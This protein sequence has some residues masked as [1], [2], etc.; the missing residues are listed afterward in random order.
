M[1]RVPETAEGRVRAEIA[2]GLAAG[3]KEMRDGNR[4]R[5]RAACYLTGG[6]LACNGSRSLSFCDPLM[7]CPNILGPNMNPFRR[8][9]GLQS[10]QTQPTKLS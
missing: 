8:A 4:C 5:C 10:E 2:R 1:L 7:V 3:W 6:M 9:P